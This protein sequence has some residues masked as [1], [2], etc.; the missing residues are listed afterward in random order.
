MTVSRDATVLHVKIADEHVSGKRHRTHHWHRYSCELMNF[1]V[2]AQ[3]KNTCDIDKQICNVLV[4]D[5]TVKVI[6][7]SSHES[8]RQLTFDKMRN[9]NIVSYYAD[10][11]LEPRRCVSRMLLWKLMRLQC[12][13]VLF[14]NDK[15]LN[16]N[17]CGPSPH[18]LGNPWRI[19]GHECF[20]SGEKH[21][22]VSRE[23][24][25]NVAKKVA[26]FFF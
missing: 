3:R 6:C 1:R 21:R 4:V 23:Y 14:P 18:V 5:G 19:T 15:S 2:L 10:N 9:D 11:D 12:T 13:L 7:D 26:E 25:D 22:R 16:V 17:A 8:P 20:S 24:P